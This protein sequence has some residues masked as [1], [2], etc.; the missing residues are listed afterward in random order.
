M[1]MPDPWL[2]K[3]AILLAVVLWVTPVL[4]APPLPYSPWGTVRIDGAVAPAGVPVSAWIDGVRFAT[5]PILTGGWYSLD[6]RG[7]DGDTP[8]KDGGVSGDE[9]LFRVGESVATQRGVWRSGDSPRLDL[10]VQNQGMSH[11]IV[12]PLILRY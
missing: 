2:R 12:L 8:T 3:A 10:E 7:D 4:A 9:V 6:V 1:R 11:R 5:T